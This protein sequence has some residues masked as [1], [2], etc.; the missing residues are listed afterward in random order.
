MKIFFSNI[1]KTQSS[2]VECCC[3]WGA[4]QLRYSIFILFWGSYGS[5]AL[6]IDMHWVTDPAK[7]CSASLLMLDFTMMTTL[8]PGTIGSNFTADWRVSLLTFSRMQTK[9]K[10][11][12]QYSH[13][14][15]W[16]WGV[17]SWTLTLGPQRNSTGTRNLHAVN[18]KLVLFFFTKM[19][20]DVQGQAAHNSSSQCS[21]HS[22]SVLTETPFR[23]L[24]AH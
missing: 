22:M 24:F 14:L 17:C 7:T 9:G 3:P 19:E 15:P 12:K 16:C 8:L 6:L 18:P 10:T 2:W 5:S 13:I 21:Q 20:P 1:F 4:K 11:H 23:S